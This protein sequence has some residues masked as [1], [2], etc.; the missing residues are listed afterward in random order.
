[1]K[2]SEMHSTLDGENRWFQCSQDGNKLASEEEKETLH[3]WKSGANRKV[4][5]D[6]V[7]PV[8]RT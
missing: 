5:Q 2:R 3:G 7:G 8:S 4:E 1:M 6:K